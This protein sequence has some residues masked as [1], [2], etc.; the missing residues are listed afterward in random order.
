MFAKRDGE[1]VAEG[2]VEEMLE[3]LDQDDDGAIDL[4]EFW[5]EID[6]AREMG[7]S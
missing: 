7:L 3:E 5:R 4:A 2:A 1:Y 6:G